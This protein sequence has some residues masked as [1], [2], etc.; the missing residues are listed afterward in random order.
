MTIENRAIIRRVAFIGNYIPRQCG[1]ATFTTDLSEAIAKRYPE[2]ACFAMAMND[3]KEGYDYPPRVR[4]DLEQNELIS[5]ERAADYLNLNQVDVVSLQHEFGIFG[6]DAGENI[7]DVLR[8][9]HMPVVTTLHTVLDHPDQQQYRVMKDVISLSNRLVV[10]SERGVHFLKEIYHVPE[11]KIDF[12][13]HGIPDVPFV[14]PNFY[15]DGFGVEGKT[16]ILTFGLLSENKGI[17]NVIKAL[18]KIVRQRPDVMYVIL[19][20]THPNVLRSEGERY[21]NNLKGLARRLG[22]LDHVLFDNRFVTQDELVA[23]IG[24]A[25]IYI[26]PYLNKEQITSGTLAYAVGAGKAVISTPYWYAEELLADERGIL[27]G[28]NDPEAIADQ[29]ISLLENE[30]VRHA[31]RKRAYLLGRE[32]VWQKVAERYMESFERARN[33]PNAS[34]IQIFTDEKLNERAGELPSLNLFHLSRMTDTTGML[35]HAVY[36]LPNYSEGYTTDDNA[37]ALIVTIL[38]EQLGEEWLAGSQELSNRYLAF[39]WHA[40]NQENGRFRNFMGYQ[41]AWLEETGSED[42]HGRALWAAGVTIGRSEHTVLRSVA[43]RLFNWGVERALDLTSP[44]AWAF[45]LLGI[46]EY[47]RQ[48]RGDRIAASA[49]IELAE[50]LMDQYVALNQ[51]DWHWFENNVTYCNAVLSHALL[52]VGEWAERKEMIDAGLESLTW[53]L[54]NQKTPEGYFNPIGSHGFLTRGGERA[55]FDQQPVEA[56]TTISACLRANRITGDD[57][58]LSEA[59]V[60]FDWY[61]GAN[62]LGKPLYDPTSGGCMDGIHPDRV[63]QNQGAESTLSFLLSLLELRLAKR[64]SEPGKSE[65]SSDVKLLTIHAPVDRDG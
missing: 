23:Y 54:Q 50:R 31:M 38:L 2:T 17:E 1:I 6:G 41:R 47:L 15:K 45:T 49:G 46:D 34:P 63:N 26:T 64:M 35:Q 61:L 44:R 20:A 19:G 36:S 12:I 30:A 3:R 33:E 51:P 65:Q 27:V 25:D 16:V 56:Q 43:S 53:L 8:E 18:P 22:V 24:A 60:C 14:D 13:P 52:T 4:F 5:Y 11:D 55:V 62:V 21:R 9:I 57:T 39:L 29:V 32:M 58:W 40:Y 28:F 7:L 42:S 10:M 37:R 59:R 48:F